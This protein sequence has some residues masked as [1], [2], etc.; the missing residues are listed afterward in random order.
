MLGDSG[1][2]DMQAEKSL[3]SEFEERSHFLLSGY[4]AAVV[5][6]ASK[7]FSERQEWRRISRYI[8]VAEYDRLKS[9]RSPMSQLTSYDQPLTRIYSDKASPRSRRCENEK[10]T[11]KNSRR[12]K[13]EGMPKTPFENQRKLCLE[14]IIRYR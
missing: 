9:H 8:S 13:N 3:G 4:P 14:M 6:A 7:D 12:K 5:A 10:G 1:N 2:W 11:E